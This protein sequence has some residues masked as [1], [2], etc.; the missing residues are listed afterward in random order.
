M[1]VQSPLIWMNLCAI[2]LGVLVN[3]GVLDTRFSISY[4]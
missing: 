2:N 3:P 4:T 1:L